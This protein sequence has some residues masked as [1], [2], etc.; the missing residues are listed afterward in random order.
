RRAAE[1][2]AALEDA[3]IDARRV[4]ARGAEADKAEWQILVSTKQLSVARKLV[5]DVVAGRKSLPRQF[6]F[7]RSVWV[8]IGVILAVIWGLLLLG[9][10]PVFCG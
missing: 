8:A 1:W 7:G 2:L 10:A 5:S 3:G 4:E 9:G 6:L